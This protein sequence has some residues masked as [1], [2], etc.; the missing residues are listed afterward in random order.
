[1]RQLIYY[2]IPGKVFA[3]A[4]DAEALLHL[5]DV[6]HRINAARIA[7]FIE[8]M[9]AADLT[10]TFF[11]G[12][13]R[14]PPAHALIFENGQLRQ[15]RYWQL[16]APPL[17]K[18]AD[19]A[20]YAEAFLDV[21]TEAVRARLRSPDPVGS[22]LSGGM[23]SGSVTAIAAR[24]SQKEGSLPLKT[25]SA[26]GTDP[27]CRETNAIMAALAIPHIDPQFVSLGEPDSF[28]DE[29]A[30]LTRE[31]SEPF[32][33]HMALIRAI[34]VAAQRGGVKV[35]LD[36]VG[37]DTTVT[38]GDMIA[39]QLGQWRVHRA[40]QEAQAQERFWSGELPAF[41]EFATAMKRA[42][43]PGWLRALRR[44]RWERIEAGR[45]QRESLISPELEVQLDMPTRR[46][47]NAKHLQIPH[48]CDPQTQ[49]LRQG[50][51]RA[52]DRTA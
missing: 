40:W 45:A 6:P 34:Y 48:G 20:A 16:T 37:G 9:E 3:L 17:L 14:L 28:R 39:F 51:R 46:R 52:R 31:S 4:T 2:H 22:M 5:P 38:T 41:K 42:L 33:G 18:R 19:D 10:S 32:D 15:W 1:M 47:A 26:I 35:M 11:E 30:K 13:R 50:R 29:V 44:P 49:A 43:V 23:D 24:L 25:F 27:G 8:Q 12:V 7:D 21:F 36:G